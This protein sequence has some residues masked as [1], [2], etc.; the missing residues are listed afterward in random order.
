[1]D[2]ERARRRTRRGLARRH[3]SWELV[4]GRQ[5]ARRLPVSCLLGVLGVMLGCAV[6]DA[7]GSLESGSADGAGLARMLDGMQHGLV[8]GFF[9]TPA[10]IVQL[11]PLLVCMRAP[12]VIMRFGGAARSAW[13]MVRRSMLLAAVQALLL[14]SLM[15]LALIVRRIQLP[16]GDMLAGF[17]SCELLALT[18][19]FE[20]CSIVLVVACL[21][22]P[23]S[24][25]VPVVATFAYGLLDYFV[26]L[27]PLKSLGLMQFGWAAVRAV[28]V[29]PSS[30]LGSLVRMA[31][32][33]A[34]G[35]LL[36]SLLASSCDCLSFEDGE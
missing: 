8:A 11:A 21:L 13:V 36:I 20:G 3:A 19:Y 23:G 10:C 26:V 25:T 2:E 24:M 29:G 16:Q 5:L 32:L 4:V 34:A 6:A 1:M 18:L 33:C 30:A 7:S 22:R 28:S 15:L 14:G 12:H 31:F 27:S 35:V 9:Y 17:L